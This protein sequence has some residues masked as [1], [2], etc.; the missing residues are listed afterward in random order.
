MRGVGQ[1][2]DAVQ[3]GHVI[4]VGLGQFWAEIMIALPPNDQ[5]GRLDR[6]KCRFGP[7]GRGSYRGAIIVDHPGCCAWL[8][9]CLDVAIDFLCRESRVGVAQEVPEEPPAVGVHD[10]LGKLRESKE[11]EV[12][13]LPKL[14]RVVQALQ[15][16]P[17]MGRVEDGQP[18]HDLGVVHRGSPGH[19]ST[20]VVAGQ[21]CRV[22]ASFL[23]EAADVGGEPVGVVGRDADRP[24]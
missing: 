17:R 23:D 11:E 3:V 4:A 6:A 24:R 2:L 19:G 18:V 9:P 22:G 13:R 7:L 15:Q 8:R 10:G 21:H 12:P 14:V 20:P 5:C 16:L 1:A